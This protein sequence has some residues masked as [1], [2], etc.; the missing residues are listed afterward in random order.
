M[1]SGLPLAHGPLS[2]RAEPGPLGPRGAAP[3]APLRRRHTCR[4][5]LP[6]AIQA[7]F[8]PKWKGGTV[9]EG[10]ALAAA[11]Q[12]SGQRAP[13]AACFI[14]DRTWPPILQA[15][16]PLHGDT[17]LQ[18]WGVSPSATM[19]CS[20]PPCLVGACMYPYMQAAINATA[21]VFEERLEA[22]DVMAL[23][24][25]GETFLIEPTRKGGREAELLRVIK[26]SNQPGGEC[27]LYSS[28]SQALKG[29]AKQDP[30]YS[31]WLIVLTDL[32]DLSA[33]DP[34]VT[35]ALAR[36]V[37]D[38]MN[39]LEVRRSKCSHS[40]CSHRNYSHSKYSHSKWQWAEELE[41]R[42]HVT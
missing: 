18:S 11:L 9:E 42:H 2:S 15:R 17:P 10:G 26:G 12:L 38:E 8:D 32:V 1:P 40:K 22:D 4:I 41:E 39:R 14:I 28:M 19:L 35:S 27:K 23:Y 33:R 24:S 34:A 16:V 37:L 31:K 30:A 3:G 5:R 6:L 36:G 7:S 13:M 20:L 25:L 29:M 21:M